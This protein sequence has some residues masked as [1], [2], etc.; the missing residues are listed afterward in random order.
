MF[1]ENIQN[2]KN[3]NLPLVLGANRHTYF[4][5]LKCSYSWNFEHPKQTKYKNIFMTYT[6]IVGTSKP[7][8]KPCLYYYIYAEL[9]IN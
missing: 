4:F 6:V 9:L 1:I 7:S 2:F 5:V 3:I 8:Q